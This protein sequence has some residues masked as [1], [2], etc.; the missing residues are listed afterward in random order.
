MTVREAV[1]DLYDLA[2]EPSNLDPWNINTVDYDIEVDL[3]PDSRG[4]AHWLR[5][6]STAQHILANWR[7][8]S[9][10]PIRFDKFQTRKNIK[11]GLETQGFTAVRFAGESHTLRL[12]APPAYIEPALLEGAR[13][14]ILYTGAGPRD[15]FEQSIEIV[16]A[17]QNGVNIDLS[18]REPLEDPTFTATST[19]VSLY[20]NKFQIRRLDTRPDEAYVVALP[21]SFRNITKIIDMASSSEAFLAESKEALDDYILGF[22]SPTYY[23]V[24]GDTLY[25]NQYIEDPMWFTIEY[26]RNPFNLRSLDD[27]FDI[28]EQWHEVLL[29]LVQWKTAKRLHENE[30]S[31]M[32][33][34]EI[35]R[36]IDSLRTD[37]EERWVRTN[38]SGFYIRKEAR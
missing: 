6:L 16:I 10:R 3:E 8:R 37:A 23:Y 20:F 5:Q 15:S 2:G 1:V 11:L 36:F 19:T 27:N 24:N 9:G 12:V 32:I 31:Q 14:D 7:T 13:C 30:K 35:N 38:T 22:G 29:L 18:F 34:A 28:P 33:L 25:F 26:Q 4:V 21:S 17:D